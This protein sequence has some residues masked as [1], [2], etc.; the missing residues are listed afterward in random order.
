[1]PRVVSRNY[2][3]DLLDEEWRAIE[4]LVP[5]PN[6]GGRRQKIEIRKTINAILY[7]NRTKCP[8]RLLPNDFPHWRSTYGYFARWRK[9]GTWNKIIETLD[10]L[11]RKNLWIR[12]TIQ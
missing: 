8:W 10:T 12:N 3:S 2:P 5:P 11:G 7:R 9:D 1:M 4:L 6:R